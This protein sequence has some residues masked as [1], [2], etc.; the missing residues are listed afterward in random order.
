MAHLKT[1]KLCVLTWALLF[2][3]AECPNEIIY[4]GLH[5]DIQSFSI[6]MPISTHEIYLFL[7]E[8][9]HIEYK[10][11]SQI[12]SENNGHCCLKKPLLKPP[13]KHFAPKWLNFPIVEKG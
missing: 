4:Y 7:N 11:F 12:F 10:L 5:W 1:N 6:T 9:L 13:F 8:P 3:M 2:K